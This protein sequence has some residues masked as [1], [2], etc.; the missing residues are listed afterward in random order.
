MESDGNNIVENGIAALEDDVSG[1]DLKENE[2][3]DCRS[4]SSAV[5]ITVDTVATPPRSDDE[6]ED[7]P[8]ADCGNQ[9]D[10]A[11]VNN[12][13]T[14]KE[15]EEDRK[16]EDGKEEDGIPGVAKL[17]EESQANVD[18]HSPSSDESTKSGNSIV[19]VATQEPNAADD[20]AEAM[21]QEEDED[22]EMS[23][24]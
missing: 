17:E 21:D 15:V 6:E 4:C 24:R 12:N 18:Q 7:H 10:E 2:E 13:A 8:E 20:P 11:V 1:T 19:E 23:L 14:S 9:N 16:D 22:Y 3:F 5:I